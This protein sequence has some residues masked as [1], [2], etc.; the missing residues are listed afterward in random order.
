MSHTITLL[1]DSA[2]S[3]R[4]HIATLDAIRHAADHRG[5]EVAVDVVNTDR[6]GE[7]GD[8]IVIGPGAPY[9]DPAAAEEAI[10]TARLEGIPLVGT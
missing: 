1:I 9:R 3:A 2:P 5:I 4:F 8:G 7:L 10:R 6:V